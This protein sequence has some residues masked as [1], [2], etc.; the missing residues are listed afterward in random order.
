MAPKMKAGDWSTKRFEVNQLFTPSTPIT[1]AELFAGRQDQLFRIVDGIGE[2]GRHIILFGERGV[3]KTSLAQVVPYVLPE[4]PDR[5]A[6]SRVQCFP[7]DNFSSICKKI[8]KNIRFSADIGDGVKTYDVSDMYP[9]DVAPDDF[10]REAS[11]FNEN[12]IPIIVIDEFNE[13][14]DQEAPLL[15]ANTIKALSDAG[16][17]I[18]LI[19][20][21]VADNVTELIKSHA[22]IERCT[23][24][25]LMPRMTASE[26]K[27]IIEKRLKQLGMTIEADAKW[28]IINL[29]KGLPQ[30][31]HGLG[32]L[33]CFEAIKARRLDLSTSDTDKA[34]LDL[35][36]TSEQSFKRNYDEAT[37]SNQPDNLF[38]Q[39]LTACALAKA[40]ENGYFAPA[41]VREPLAGILGRPVSVAT[42]Q[43][44][45]ADFSE[46]RGKILQ[47]IGEARSYR[48]RF[49]HPAM[50][51]YV[52]MRGI[53]EGI[54]D[55]SAKQA[56]S[57]PG[58][59]DLF[60]SE[61]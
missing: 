13:I 44:H 2:R 5:I 15:F 41:A 60:S 49:R 21:G 12:K 58:D 23:S 32:K 20:V 30:Y 27:E 3:G 50:Q 29:A 10:I 6:F 34:I 40:D 16:T 38:R 53:E 35:L 24:E 1:V 28:K 18:T 61:C 39:V 19:I 55:E 31:V 14:G 46:K 26:L 4:K 11:I 8:F 33:S 7:T 51:P 22:S 54:V 45:L 25:I 47:R 56:L 48:L 36:E 17:N 42:F 59:P 37:R 43:N 9:G 52:I 57:F